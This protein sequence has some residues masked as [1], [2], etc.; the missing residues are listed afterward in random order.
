[1]KKLVLAVVAACLLFPVTGFAWLD[2]LE[3]RPEYYDLHPG[4]G[5]RDAGTWQNPYIIRDR[6]GT[7]MYKLMPKF[8]DLHPGDGSRD[9]GTWQ[10]PY[11]IEKIR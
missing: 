4:D 11:V 3:I 9:A 10:N 1:M 6:R 5:S 8:P 7:P 2:D